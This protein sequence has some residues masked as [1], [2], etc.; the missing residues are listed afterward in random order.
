MFRCWVDWD[1]SPGE[2]NMDWLTAATAKCNSLEPL[3]S[4]LVEIVELLVSIALCTPYFNKLRPSLGVG[5]AE[6]QLLFPF[7]PSTPVLPDP[8]KHLK[9][10][11]QTF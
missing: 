6:N 7:Q 5:G 11:C 8:A 2:L 4:L 9:V 1:S 10:L 3:D